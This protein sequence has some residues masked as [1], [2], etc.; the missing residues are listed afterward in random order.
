MFKL[1]E[2]KIRRRAWV[3]S[4]GIPAARLGWTLDDCKET[5][6]ADI[7]KINRWSDAVKD[8]KIIRAYGSKNCGRGLL[9]A[10]APG[11]G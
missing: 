5:Y 4:A 6:P 9:L 11:R 3:Q 10:G 2:L 1:S 8:S 7:E